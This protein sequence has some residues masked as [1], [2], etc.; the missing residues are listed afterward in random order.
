[1]GTP[2]ARGVRPVP[3]YR[4]GS[5]TYQLHYDVAYNAWFWQ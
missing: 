1:M 4:Y 2:L 3:G 5:V